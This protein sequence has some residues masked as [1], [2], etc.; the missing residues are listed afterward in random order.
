MKFDVI[1]IG[2]GR[3]GTEIG[4]ALQ[5]S[6]INC[7]I[8]A[9]GL[10]INPS[11]RTEFVACGG[12]LLPGDSVVGGGFDGAVLKNVRTE[13]LVGTVLEADFFVLATGKFF[14]GGL[15][16]TMD[17]IYE[18][19]FGCDVQY[20]TDKEKW[21]NPDFYADQPFERFGVVTDDSGRVSVKG[22]TIDN[23]YA[24]GEILAGAVD[25]DGSAALVTAQIMGRK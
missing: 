6:G 23:L 24:A 19:V 4:A 11:K 7:L 22:V 17:G 18:P 2:G 15:V 14:S 1:I 16:S 25:I 3:A 5:K 13:N 9:K 10:S 20:E 21:V 8:V 12:T